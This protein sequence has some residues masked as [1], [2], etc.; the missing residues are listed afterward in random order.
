MFPQISRTPDFE[1]RFLEKRCG[2]SAG[3]YGISMGRDLKQWPGMCLGHNSVGNANQDIAKVERFMLFFDA[4]NTSQ[5]SV[6]QFEISQ[7]FNMER[8]LGSSCLEVKPCVQPFC[9]PMDYFGDS[10]AILKVP[11]GRPTTPCETCNDLFL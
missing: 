4:A 6:K 11:P 5:T 8:I 9:S 3:V 2:L 10:A 1:R 7:L